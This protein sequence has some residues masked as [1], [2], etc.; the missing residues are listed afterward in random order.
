MSTGL[1]GRCIEQDDVIVR[2]RPLNQAGL[3]REGE[4]GLSTWNVIADQP[5]RSRRGITGRSGRH[6]P[7][8]HRS[9][10]ND[11]KGPASESNTGC[12]GATPGR[13]KSDSLETIE[14]C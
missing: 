7:E 2:D 5:G 1:A 8:G 10:T 14:G 4:K 3:Q 13:E 9:E 11:D 12:H 6:T